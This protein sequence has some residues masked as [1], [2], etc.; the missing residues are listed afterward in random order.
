MKY[1]IQKIVTAVDDINI[2][3]AAAVYYDLMGNKV[4]NPENGIF[5]KMVGNKATKI[6]M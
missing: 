5:I 6:K 3:E 4:A 1:S 2:E